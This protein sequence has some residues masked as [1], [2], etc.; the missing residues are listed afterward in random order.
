MHTENNC[1]NN[2]VATMQHMKS[3]FAH[4]LIGNK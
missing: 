1:Y 4:V 3:P 2:F